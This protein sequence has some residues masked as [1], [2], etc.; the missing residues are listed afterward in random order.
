MNKTDQ[1]FATAQK[2]MSSGNYSQ[3]INILNNLLSPD[4]GK[5]SHLMMRGEAYLR[6]EQFDAALAD[7]A[8]VV[9]I[10]NK[11]ITA[12]NNFAVALIRCN[13]QN[14]AKEILE[15]VLEIEPSNFD[16]HINLGNV[17]QTQYKS[18]EA[19][20]IALRAIAI[21]PG[22]AI[23]Y[24]NLGTALGDLNHI[25]EAREA[26]LT[27][28]AIDP[29]YVSTYINLAQIEEKLENREQAK[30]LYEQ[31]LQLKNLT[32][33]ESDLIKYYLAYSYL[34]FGELEKGWHHY[35]YGFGPL[36]PIGALRSLRKFSQPKWSGEPLNGRKL[37]IWRE[38]GLGDEID[39]S[40][41]LIDLAELGGEVILET[42]IRLIKTYQRTFKNFLIREQME[43]ADNYPLINDFD[44]HCPIGSLPC[45]FRKSI[46]NFQ[47][48]TNLF[49][50]DAAIKEQF[51]QLLLP[52]KEY[53]LVGI[54]WRSGKLSVLRNL[55]YTAL[56]DWKELLGKP[57]VKFVNLQY[58]D[59]ESELLEIE[60]NL[61][62]E[63]LRWQDLDLKNNLEAV[64]ALCSCLDCVVSVGTAVSS[65]APAVGCHTFLLAKRSWI[66]LG[67]EDRYPWYN[68][69]TPLLAS[70]NEHI[71]KKIELVYDL[72]IKRIKK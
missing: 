17:L 28:N 54:S 37:L 19:L 58:G 57:N 52:Y 2:S 69:V 61:G 46:G 35:D 50:P 14:N 42:D 53:I 5:V 15:Y 70:K 26:Y 16:A 48:K 7:Y 1:L 20:Q 44:V 47:N 27:A 31:A 13:K 71:A 65:I 3:A 51:Q 62:I 11:N 29:N 67:Q 23:A 63:I 25:E 9:E 4:S 38:Q 22:S 56:V 36:L 59:C 64:I 10:D 33:Y 40:T 8:K 66:M 43:G 12:L 49:S 72:I 60:K 32:H 21:N 18:Q 68:C 41:C 55:N 39:F 34:F 30:N 45:I 24:N 6:S